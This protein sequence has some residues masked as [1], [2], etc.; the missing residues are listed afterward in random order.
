MEPNPDIV[1]GDG[2]ILAPFGAEM[3]DVPHGR[4]SRREQRMHEANREWA[5]AFHREMR[6][7]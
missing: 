1:I 2:I 3:E 4:R 6:R 7:G 5:A